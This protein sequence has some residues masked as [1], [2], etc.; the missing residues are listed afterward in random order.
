MTLK[1]LLEVKKELKPLK[2]IEIDFVIKK[3]SLDG[4][5]KDIN[6]SF[7]ID[8]SALYMKAYDGLASFSYTAYKEKDKGMVGS[9]PRNFAK[10][11]KL[12]QHMIDKNIKKITYSDFWD[13]L[14]DY[15]IATYAN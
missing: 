4:R 10:V 8:D 11:R 1:S 15:D 9:G 7:S 12:H 5:D 6:A 13:Y 2:K 3:G 14:K